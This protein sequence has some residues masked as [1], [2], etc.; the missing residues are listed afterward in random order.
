MQ[1][2][3]DGCLVHLSELYEASYLSLRLICLNLDEANSSDCDLT[4]CYCTQL[5][6]GTFRNSSVLILE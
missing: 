5:F 1:G 4:V 3:A 6:S 2:K